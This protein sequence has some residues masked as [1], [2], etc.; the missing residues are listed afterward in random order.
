MRTLVAAAF[1]VCVG[2]QVLAAWRRRHRPWRYQVAL[3]SVALITLLVML[4]VFL[5]V[6]PQPAM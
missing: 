3:A 5:S 1:A 4:W 6:M 2:L